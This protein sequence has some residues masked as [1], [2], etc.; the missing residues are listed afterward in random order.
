MPAA[1]CAPISSGTRSAFNARGS[2]CACRRDTTSYWS[3]GAYGRRRD[4]WVMSGNGV[5]ITDNMS[6]RTKMEEIGMSD[7]EMVKVRHIQV[8]SQELADALKGQLEREE[9]TFGELARLVS[10]CES[11]SRG[12]DLGWVRRGMMVKGFEDYVFGMDVGVVDK[13]KTEFGWHLVVVEGRAVGG[14]EMSVDELSRRKREVGQGIVVVDVRERGEVEQVP[15]K[16]FDIVWLPMGEYGRWAG[17]FENNKVGLGEGDK[18]I[19][20]MCHHGV[21]SKEF[22]KFLGQAGYRNVR[23]LTGGIH[24]WAEEIDPTVGFY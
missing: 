3:N 16:G 8:E 21:R 7:E 15:F 22:C 2:L 12:G 5:N 24:Q 6:S 17:D 9:C 23:N 13:I 10:Q 11:K 18:E 20:V 1:F 4:V 14:T 19:V